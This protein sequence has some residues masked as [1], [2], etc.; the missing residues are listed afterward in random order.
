[1]RAYYK[2]SHYRHL[3]DPESFLESTIPT[4]LSGQWL[5]NARIAW[6]LTARPFDLSA[7]IEAYNLLD[8]RV[9][10]FAG[11]SFANEPDHSGERMD[12]RIV[13]FLQ[14]QLD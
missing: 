3:P 13:L 6:K 8:Q 2:S 7:G 9:R 4:K 11:Q 1:L 10:Q 5:L 12:R 14:G